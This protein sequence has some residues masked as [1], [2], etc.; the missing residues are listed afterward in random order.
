MTAERT[1]EYGEISRFGVEEFVAGDEWVLRTACAQNR[2]WNDAFNSQLQVAVNFSSRQFQDPNLLELILEV[3]KETGMAAEALE[4]EI[5]ESIAMK[6]IDRTTATLNELNAM[7]I[8]IS[9][10]D[11]G[12]GYSSLGS[13]KRFPIKT[14]KIDESFIRDMTNDS[15]DAALTA[16]IIAM[17]HRMKMQV[18]PR[19]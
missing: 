12:T 6:N 7:G 16:A 10:D 14:L 19:G 17:A 13:L 8:Q 4:L 18:M 15:D 2:A 1:D 5:T 9:I 11:F 3:L